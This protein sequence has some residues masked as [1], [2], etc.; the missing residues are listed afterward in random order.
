MIPPPWQIQP[1]NATK[2]IEGSVVS[3]PDEP[4][5][6]SP[7]VLNEPPLLD[8]ASNNY[9]VLPLVGGSRSERY[10]R[11]MHM[12]GKFHNQQSIHERKVYVLEY[13]KDFSST[14]ALRRL[15]V[16]KTNA[17][18]AAKAKRFMR[19]GYVLLLISMVL[20]EM[21]EDA[22]ATRKEVLTSLKQEMNCF[23]TDATS[24]SRVAAAKALGKLLGMEVDRSIS[25]SL[26]AQAPREINEKDSKEFLAMLESK[27]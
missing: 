22:I 7:A 17:Y 10:K 3:V 26:S 20:E 5:T 12:E 1:Q 18:Y 9:S 23:D 27:F 15:F 19:C 11:L 24:A 14:K 8:S 13:I 25:L 4:L 21:E 6:S 2:V 16:G